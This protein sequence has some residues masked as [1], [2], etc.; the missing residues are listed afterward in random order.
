MNLKKELEKVREKAI[1]INAISNE[2]RNRILQKASQLLLM[3]KEKILK[4][5]KKDLENAKKKGMSPAFIDRLLLNEKRIAEMAAALKDVSKLKL[6]IGEVL[7]KIRRPNGIVIK[8]VRVP[9]GVVFVIYEARPN[10]TSDS[11]ALCFK[12]GNAVVL[13]GG[14]DAINSNRAIFSLITKAI[15]PKIRDAF[16]FVDDTSRKTVLEILKMKEFIDVVIPRGGEGLINTVVSNSAVPVLYHGKGLCHLYVHEKAK[17]PMAIKIAVNAK[18]Q[19]PGV[20]NAIENLL[21]D[22]KIAKKFLPQLY[23]VYQ[24]HQMEMRGCPETLK[25]LKGIKKA[26]ASD[27]DTEY[28]AKIISI[29]VVK[30]IDE[31][32]DFI[33]IHSSRHSDA[34]VTEDKS[35]AKKFF[36]LVDSA[37]IYHNASTRF[38][39][40]G[41][42][43]MGAEIGISNQKLHARGP[44]GVEELTIYKYVVTGNGQIRK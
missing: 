43:G 5:N 33:N 29:K 34:I 40:G 17:I 38:T 13:R 41:Q 22:K 8:K 24:E 12:S 20:C 15:P 18:V 21:V 26:K 2:E 35:A 30:D 4:E 32:I 9:L 19:R 11:F 7:K 3:G 27:W 25:I 39:D 28:L 10:V 6:K 23:R 1:L 31:A 36:T 16:L 14:S 42:F 44:V 37:C